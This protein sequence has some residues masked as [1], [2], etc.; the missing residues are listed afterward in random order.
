MLPDAPAK[1]AGILYWRGFKTPRAIAAALLLHATTIHSHSPF[2]PAALLR[3]HAIPLP[4]GHAANSN[5][6]LQLL[7][8]NSIPL[9]CRTDLR[10]NIV[11]V[12]CVPLAQ[13]DRVSDSDSEGRA[14]ESRMAR[15]LK[16]PENAVFSGDFAIWEHLALYCSSAESV[17]FMP[18]FY[19]YSFCVLVKMPVRA[20]Q[21]K[22]QRPRCRK[23]LLPVL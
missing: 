4:L 18:L 13:L 1:I 23:V 17:S 21:T 19:T 3:P 22:K 10:Y 9:D 11:V 6:A 7:N 14:F 2:S 8:L 16:S 15:Q 5:G 12:S 20:G